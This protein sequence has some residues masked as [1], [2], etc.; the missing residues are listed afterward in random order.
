MKTKVIM[1]MLA[2]TIGAFG[3]TACDNNRSAEEQVEDAGEEI[4]DAF[5]TESEELRA[6]LKEI[7]DD[8]DTRIAELKA[9][10]ENAGEDAQAEMQ[11]EID[12]LEAWGNEIDGRMDR[13]GEN[14]A[15][16]WENFKSDTKQTMENINRE[17]EDLIDG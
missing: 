11:E 16:G 4:S 12:Q 7:G 5:R 15:D 1:F 9:D 6:D 17:L 3:F 10:M 2:L 8:I 14:I 13:L